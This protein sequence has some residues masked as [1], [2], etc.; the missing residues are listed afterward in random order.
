MKTEFNG[1]GEVANLHQHGADGW[2]L[3]KGTVKCKGLLPLPPLEAQQLRL[4]RRIHSGCL[5]DANDIRQQRRLS[6]IGTLNEALHEFPRQ[7]A[8]RIIA[9]SSFS[10]SQGQKAKYSLRADVFRFTPGSGHP[11]CGLEC[12]SCANNGSQRCYSIT[13][14]AWASSDDGTVRPSALAV[15][16]LMTSSNLVG[17]ST[18][19][20][21]GRAPWRILKT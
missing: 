13:S 12:P 1:I 15:L 14:S 21:D 18:G 2:H 4:Q 9:D 17:R 5:G 11:A 10:R 20:S 3:K 7:I 16:R 19:R 6:A 8:K